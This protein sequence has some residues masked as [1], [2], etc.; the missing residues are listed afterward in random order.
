M[1]DRATGRSRGFGYVTFS[2][3]HDAVTAVNQMDEQ[4]LDGR[5]IKV[6]IAGD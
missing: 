2:T 5:I 4:E 3:S 1:V 6:G